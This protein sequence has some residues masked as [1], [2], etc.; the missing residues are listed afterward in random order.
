MFDSLELVNAV[1]VYRV[2]CPAGGAAAA[3][4]P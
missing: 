2:A 4:V 1:I 3:A